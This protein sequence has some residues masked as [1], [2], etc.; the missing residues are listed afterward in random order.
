MTSLLIL[1]LCFSLLYG[2][3]NS[4]SESNKNIEYDG[5]YLKIG[6]IGD[7]SLPKFNN[8]SYENKTLESLVNSELEFDALIITENAFPEA[9]KNKYV[10][11]YNKVK[12][13]VFFFGI[14]GF[15]DF[16][17]TKQ[18]ITMDMARDENSAY[19][20]GFKDPSGEN[21]QHWKF[22]LPEGSNSQK[23]NDQKMLL[24]I[25]EVLN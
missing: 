7:S 23:N 8:I 2:C 5:D 18:D 1:L 20:Q 10:S 12:Y 17:F 3:S 21:S 6:V 14:D 11:F 25:F 9:D 15:R 16:A 24:R 19:V 22:Y 4:N 13:P